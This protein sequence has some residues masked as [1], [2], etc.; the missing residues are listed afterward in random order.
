MGIA[1]IEAAYQHH[2]L[3]AGGEGRRIEVV[4]WTDDA[5]AAI[6]RLTAANPTAGAEKQEHEGRDSM[7]RTLGELLSSRSQPPMQYVP[8]IEHLRGRCVPQHVSAKRSFTAFPA[9]HFLD[10]GGGMV[11][12]PSP[13]P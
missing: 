9:C 3:A 4:L 10:I 11:Q 12:S 6:K 13:C 1:A 7:N 5:D 2:G 8:D